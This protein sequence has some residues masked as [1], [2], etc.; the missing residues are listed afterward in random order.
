MLSNCSVPGETTPTRPPWRQCGRIS[1]LGS[2]SWA[3]NHLLQVQPHFAKLTQL[4][5]W[6]LIAIKV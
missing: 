6:V 4:A 3:S 1:K 5:A 2:T